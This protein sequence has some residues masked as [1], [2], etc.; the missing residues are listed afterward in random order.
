MKTLLLSIALLCCATLPTASDSF[1]DLSNS[2]N[3]LVQT[4]KTMT[5]IMHTQSDLIDEEVSTIQEMVNTGNPHIGRI[6]LKHYPKLVS[7]L[8]QIQEVRP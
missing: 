1:T 7:L 2:M 4:N 8:H 3:R 5:H 6:Y